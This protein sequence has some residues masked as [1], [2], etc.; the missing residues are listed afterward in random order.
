MVGQRIVKVLAAALLGLF[1]FGLSAA[2]EQHPKSVPVG[3]VFVQPAKLAPVVPAQA[4]FPRGAKP[5]PRHKVLAA[6]RFAAQAAAPAQFAVVPKQLSMWGN[7]QDGDCVSAESAFAL[8]WFSTYATGTEVFVSTAEVQRWARKYGFLNGAM[9]TDVMDVQQKDGFN[10]NGVNYRQGPYFSVDFSN[11][12]TLQAA[13]STGAVSIA[14]DANALPSGAGNKSGWYA[15]G[16]GRYPNTDHCVGLFCY[17]PAQWV[18]QQYGIP[19]PST[20]SPTKMVYGIF[21]WNTIGVVDHQWLTSTCVEA[22]YRNPT[23]AGMAPQ[24]PTP[25][26]PPVPPVPPIPPTPNV[27]FTGTITVTTPYVN[28]VPGQPVT[29]VTTKSLQAELEAAG[30]NPKIILDV[31][32]LVADIKAKAPRDVILADLFAIINDLTGP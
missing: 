13:I 5:S 30:V 26:V 2:P 9:L 22:W 15:F 16:S 21:T 31:L 7:D 20:V 4:G 29:T 19:L 17:G 32:K 28:G 8:A 27:P 3:K 24:P 18:Y 23:I 12:A 14:I 10:V 25:P 11:E 1:A 6:P